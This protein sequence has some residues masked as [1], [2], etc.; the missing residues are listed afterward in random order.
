MV[1]RCQAKDNGLYFTLHIL[2]EFNMKKGWCT[3]TH[4]YFL[5]CKTSRFIDFFPTGQGMKHQYSIETIMLFIK[6][7]IHEETV[8]LKW[9]WLRL[10]L[11]TC[12]ILSNFVDSSHRLRSEGVDWE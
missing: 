12:D 6:S 1:P 5:T 9:W 3:Y 7:T 11:P 10:K 4:T 8:E 2:Y